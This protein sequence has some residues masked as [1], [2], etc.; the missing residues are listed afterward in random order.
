MTYFN[1]ELS[2]PFLRPCS[3]LSKSSHPF[4]HT[5]K[6]SLRHRG[7]FSHPIKI[8][9]DRASGNDASREVSSA[10]L[11]SQCRFPPSVQCISQ[12]T[13]VVVRAKHGCIQRL[14]FALLNKE[15]EEEHGTRRV[16]RSLSTLLLSLLCRY[17]LSFRTMLQDFMQI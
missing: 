13:F 4:T 11:L 16:R 2:P 12:G 7:P 10:L 8:L 15:I 5:N 6:A 14:V 1:I 17:G 9:G 3:H